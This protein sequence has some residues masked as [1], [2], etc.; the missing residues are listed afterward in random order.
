M[1]DN[2]LPESGQLAAHEFL[3]GILFE[4]WLAHA[5][6]AERERALSDLVERAQRTLYRAAE[7]ASRSD[8]RGLMSERGAIAII[9]RFVD[10]VRRQIGDTHST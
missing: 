7:A 9:Q 4:N 2:Q 6:L 3:L 1:N 10:Q 8:A 5:S